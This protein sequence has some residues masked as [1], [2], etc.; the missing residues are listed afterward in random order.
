MMLSLFCTLRKFRDVLKA[1]GK[2]ALSGCLR[3]GWRACKVLEG[4]G[5]SREGRVGRRRSM[6]ATGGG[7]D[8]S[9]KAAGSWANIVAYSSFP[10]A[11][12]GPCFSF[13]SL[14]CHDSPGGL[15]GT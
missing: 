10:C 9:G 15:Q 8:C 11:L 7:L 2:T 13:N 3:E 4:L 12:A 6:E 14:G 1:L 5:Y